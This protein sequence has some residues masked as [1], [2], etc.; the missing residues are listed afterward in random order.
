[1]VYE[2]NVSLIEGGNGGRRERR[3][4]ETGEGES[5]GERN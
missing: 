2:A 5:R 4:I 1:M 3:E